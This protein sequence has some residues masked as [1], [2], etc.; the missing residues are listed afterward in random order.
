MEQKY[1]ED[2][3]EG[4]TRW[5]DLLEVATKDLIIESP[6]GVFRWC[7]SPEVE[8]GVMKSICNYPPSLIYDRLETPILL[9]RSTKPELWNEVRDLMMLDFKKRVKNYTVMKINESHML[10]WDNPGL[11]LREIR[12]FLDG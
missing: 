7:T 12:E 6:K 11:V 9:L 2:E 4:Y 10:H 5:S 1:I 8:I 3:K